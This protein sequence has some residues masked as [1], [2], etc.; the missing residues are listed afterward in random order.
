[1]FQVLSL[2]LDLLF[3]EG[4]QLDACYCSRDPSQERQQNILF[5]LYHHLSHEANVALLPALVAAA[6]AIGSHAS[7]LLRVLCR[8]LFPSKMYAVGQLLAR[9]AYAQVRLA[10]TS[11]YPR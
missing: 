7:R 8:Q 5:L 2:A 4:G 11:A 3:C 1:M 9:G 10:S 6:A